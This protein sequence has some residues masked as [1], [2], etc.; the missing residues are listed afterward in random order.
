MK[1]GQKIRIAWRR[2]KKSVKKNVK[3]KPGIRGEWDWN[4]FKTGG[5]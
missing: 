1:K 3:I 5:K 4:E 2:W